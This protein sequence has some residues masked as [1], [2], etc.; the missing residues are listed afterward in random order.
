MSIKSLRLK[1][2]DII[3]PD[4]ENTILKND[5]MEDLETKYKK[6]ILLFD[7]DEAGLESMK[8]YKEKYPFVQMAVLPMSKDISDSIKDFGAKEVRNRLVPILDKKLNNG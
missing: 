7:N 6:I 2:L 8:K 3:A 4:S 1:H 5:L